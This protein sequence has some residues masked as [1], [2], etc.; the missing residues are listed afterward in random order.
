M[1]IHNI[2]QGSPEWFAARAGIPTASEFDKIITPATGKASTQADGYQ[3][4][5]VA[6]IIAGRP[7]QT[8]TGNIWTE[9]GKDLE[10]EA[11][12]YYAFIRG[13]E[14][15]KVGFVTDDNRTM[16][17]SPDRLVGD[18]GML[19]IKV[20]APHT[21]VEYMLSGKTEQFHRPQTQGQLLVTGRVWVDTLAYFEPKPELSIIVRSERDVEY[22][23]KL[24]G[25]LAEFNAGVQRKL[26]MLKEMAA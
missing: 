22:L 3:N 14:L 4:R 5:L 16:G 9:R 25:L 18:E 23:D 17:C 12:D 19:E 24:A 21:H 13:V 1:I 26:A 20:L 10:Q 8:F 11:A 7:L 2:E 15:E 6:E